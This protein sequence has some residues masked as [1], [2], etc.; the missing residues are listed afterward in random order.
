[1]N[2]FKSWCGDKFGGLARWSFRHKWLAVLIV[3]LVFV[4]L[5]AQLPRLTIDTSNESFFRPDDQV[6]IDYNEF[7]NQFGKDEFIVVAISGADIFNLDFLGTFNYIKGNDLSNEE[8]LAHIPPV[9]GK[10]SV[11]YRINAPAAGS[12]RIFTNEFF[13]HYSGRKYWDDMTPFGEDNE[14]E[15]I[16]GEGFPSWYTLNLRSHV[17]LSKSISFQ[18]SIE[19]ILDRFYKVFAS[20]PGAPGRNFIFTLRAHF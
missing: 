4:P 16:E 11:S 10:A 5:V 8:P 17:Q 7:R 19:N 18:L 15:A 2:A 14:D 13:I 9:F 1:M 6:L 12:T 20:G 3:L